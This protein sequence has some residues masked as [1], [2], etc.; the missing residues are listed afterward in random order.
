MENVTC[1]HEKNVYSAVLG[2][3]VLSISGKSI[4]SSVSLRTI[5]SLL[6]FCLDHLS[7]DTSGMSKCPTIV[8]LLSISSFMFVINSFKKKKDL[9]IYERHR[10]RGGDTAEGEAGSSQGARCR[11]RSRGPGIVS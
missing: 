9:L 4:W 7:I 3:S 2:W 1:A 5:V 6:I 11:T 10:E 8:E